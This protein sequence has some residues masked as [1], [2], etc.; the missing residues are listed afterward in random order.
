M[1]LKTWARQKKKRQKLQPATLTPPPTH[2][3]QA[4]GYLYLLFSL[5]SNNN[6][7]TLFAMLSLV[8]SEIR[9]F[10]HG[11]VR[12]S[13]PTPP[14]QVPPPFSFFEFYFLFRD[15][16]NR[17]C[18]PDSSSRWSCR[19]S[20]TRGVGSGSTSCGRGRGS[21][22]RRREG[23]A[24]ARLRPPP[25][26]RRRRRRRHVG[27]VENKGAVR[28]PGGPPK[29]SSSHIVGRPPCTGPARRRAIR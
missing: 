29:T 23:R 25:L 16:C 6:S 3:K 26:G 10:V 21:R 19:G 12:T 27:V 1:I 28:R 18:G 22:R 11:P 2:P 20:R 15:I 4:G 17:S 9:S 8:S 7:S 5:P 13:H 24:V 14:P